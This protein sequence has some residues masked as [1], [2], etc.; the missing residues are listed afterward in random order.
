MGDLLVRVGFQLNPRQL[1]LLTRY[2]AILLDRNRQLNLT[3]ILNLE[4]MVLKHYADCFLVARYLPELPE[5][6]LDIGSG[7]GFPGIPL[8]IL[9]PDL[10]IILGEGVRKRV[11]FLREVREE[12]GLE[13]LDIIGRNIDRDFEYPVN[14]IITRAVEPIRDTLKRASNCLMP[15]GLAI[16]MKGPN[17]D[18]EKEDAAKKFPELYLLESDYDYSLP[19]SPYRR[20][21]LVYRKR[22]REE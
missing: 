19:D 8:K 14:G 16:F 22:A 5:P 3:R 7:A 20:R 1:D 9:F 17:V 12:L 15:G 4:D 21:L 6:L 2:H 13:K 11:N 10:H 18:Q